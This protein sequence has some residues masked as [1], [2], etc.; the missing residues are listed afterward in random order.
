ML[1]FYEFVSLQEGNPLA[2]MQKFS[3]ENR[4]FIAISA[5]RP[6]MKKD[7]IKDKTSELTNYFLKRGYGVRK[8][9][10]HYEGQ[11]E[12]SIIVHA[13]AAGD[14]AGNELLAHAKLAGSKFKQDSIL[15]HDGKS[16]KLI[17]T[18]D[19][20]DA[21]AGDEIEVGGK[22]KYNDKE[23]PFQTELKPSKRNVL[24]AKRKNGN[25]ER[26]TARFTT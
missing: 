18:N 4:H 10:G 15:H 2:R 12:K 14:D 11:K 13:K 9:E 8:A 7:E 3:N 26:A 19:T 24:S 5:T 1:K 23:S 17:F 16:A 25:F 20:S 6:N 22:L 21:K